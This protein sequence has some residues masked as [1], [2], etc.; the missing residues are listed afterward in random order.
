M[1]PRKT[2]FGGATS[3]TSGARGISHW[4]QRKNIWD[5]NRSLRNFT[6][7]IG[8]RIFD[9]IHSIGKIFD[10]WRKQTQFTPPDFHHWDVCFQQGSRWAE[11]V[12]AQQYYHIVIDAS[13][14][15]KALECYDQSVS[16]WYAGGIAKAGGWESDHVRMPSSGNM[17]A[18]FSMG[19]KVMALT[20]L[21]W[22][23][24]LRSAG[25]LNGFH[26]PC[27]HDMKAAVLV[28]GEDHTALAS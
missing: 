6:R 15:A 7:W 22:T 11:S 27:C 20:N 23:D 3:A 10:F 1:P 12:A 21:Q 16:F 17:H 19:K 25:G 18:L 26:Y 8:P 13:R 28:V 5:T 9:S 2:Y 14:E 24:R 4:W